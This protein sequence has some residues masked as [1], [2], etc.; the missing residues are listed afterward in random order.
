[1]CLRTEN[2]NKH[3]SGFFNPLDGQ[4]RRVVTRSSQIEVSGRPEGAERTDH[5]DFGVGCVGQLHDLVPEAT[6]VD[7]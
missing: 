6:K 4:S 3:S 7:D 5:W 1:M 2:R